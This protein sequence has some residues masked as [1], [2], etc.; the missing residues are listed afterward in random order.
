[1]Y[2][3]ENDMMKSLVLA[4][5]LILSGIVGPLMAPTTS[6]AS[7]AYTHVSVQAVDMSAPSLTFKTMDGEVWTLPSAS[8]DILK[9]LQKGDTCSVEIDLENRVTKIVKVDSTLP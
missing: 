5:A 3:K 7:L 6:L 9:G 2:Q 1:L 4:G 8:A